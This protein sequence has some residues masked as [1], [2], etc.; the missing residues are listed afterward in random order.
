M[1]VQI[2]INIGCVESD[3]EQYFINSMKP[4]MF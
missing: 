1:S 4:P 3:M 2:I